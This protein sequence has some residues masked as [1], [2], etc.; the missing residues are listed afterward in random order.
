MKDEED[1]VLV[2]T[3]GG[4]K[5]RMDLEHGKRMGYKVKWKIIKLSQAPPKIDVVQQN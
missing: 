4:V 1:V 3:R 2:E 5:L